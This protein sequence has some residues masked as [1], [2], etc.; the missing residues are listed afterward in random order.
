MRLIFRHPS[1]TRIG[2]D[3]VA[4]RNFAAPPDGHSKRCANKGRPLRSSRGAEF[5]ELL[6][7]AAFRVSW[8]K[9]LPTYGGWREL[10]PLRPQTDLDTRLQPAVDQKE[11]VGIFSWPDGHRD[12]GYWPRG[13][14]HGDGR[15]QKGEQEA[16]PRSNNFPTDQDK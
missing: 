15:V 4:V 16:E 5:A 1:H 14:Q 12:S 11:G 8:L 7:Q 3:T 6:V 2:Q 10:A 9:A 13:K